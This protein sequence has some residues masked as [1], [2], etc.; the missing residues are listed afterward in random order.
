MS[1]D[2]YSHISHH[3]VPSLSFPLIFFRHLQTLCSISLPPVTIAYVCFVFVTCFSFAV[4]NTSPSLLHSLP[5][6]NHQPLD[7]PSPSEHYNAST[8]FMKL[9]SYS[10]Y[11]SRSMSASVALLSIYFICSGSVLLFSVNYSGIFSFSLVIPSSVIDPRIR[12]FLS[13]NLS[14]IITF[15]RHFQNSRLPCCAGY[16][17]QSLLYLYMYY[18]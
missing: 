3:L 9:C 15:N 8:A 4:V 6:I 7:L 5:F 1:F 13:D 16:I 14:R 17:V 10:I 18:A 11:T 2:L 12:S